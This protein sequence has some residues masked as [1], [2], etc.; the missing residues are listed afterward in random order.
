MQTYCQSCGELLSYRAGNKPTFCSSCG[1]SLDP[2]AK[3]VASVKKETKRIDRSEAEYDEDD[4]DDHLYVPDNI[5]K[6]DVDIQGD[7]K[8]KGMTLGSIMPQDSRDN[9]QEG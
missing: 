3:T 4:S 6:L 1:V 5:F 8:Q 2:T 7:W 9:E